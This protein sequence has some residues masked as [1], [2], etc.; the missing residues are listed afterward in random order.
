MRSQLRVSGL[1]WWP[2]KARELRHCR[3]LDTGVRSRFSYGHWGIEHT[4]DGVLL[5]WLDIVGCVFKTA[6]R[7][8]W[9]MCD[10][11]SFLFPRRDVVVPNVSRDDENWFPHTEL[12]SEYILYYGIAKRGIYKKC[13]DHHGEALGGPRAKTLGTGHQIVVCNCGRERHVLGR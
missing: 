7:S 11:V 13:L 4:D 8:L 6:L 12:N 10:L 9:D 1:N 2:G 5:V 3:K